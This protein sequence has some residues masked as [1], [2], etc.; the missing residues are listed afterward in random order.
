[1]DLY[2]SIQ[3]TPPEA[4]EDLIRKLIEQVE[5]EKIRK[6]EDS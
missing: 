2:R 5:A 4:Q 6:P 3:G 1:L